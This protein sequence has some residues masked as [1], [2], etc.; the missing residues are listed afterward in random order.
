MWCGKQHH[1]GGDLVANEAR[2]PRMMLP[3][4]LWHLGCRRRLALVVLRI[5]HA[6]SSPALTG[7]S[8]R[9]IVG[10]VELAQKRRELRAVGAGALALS[11]RTG[12]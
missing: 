3:Q 4:F 2:S 5:S 11:R 6:T 10:I 12:P 8:G 9:I 1:F 7:S